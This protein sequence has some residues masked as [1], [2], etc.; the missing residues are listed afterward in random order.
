MVAVHSIKTPI[1]TETYLKIVNLE[2][3][4]REHGSRQT[5]TVLDKVLTAWI[6]MQK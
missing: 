3:H 6:L 4:G 1:N 5:S 2:G